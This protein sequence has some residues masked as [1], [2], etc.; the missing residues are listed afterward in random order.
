MSP[1]TVLA[2]NITN[3]SAPDKKADDTVAADVHVSCQ[4]GV[5]TERHTIHHPD[6]IRNKAGND[7]SSEG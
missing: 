4:F 7:S 2:P 6:I 5:E 3:S 1:G